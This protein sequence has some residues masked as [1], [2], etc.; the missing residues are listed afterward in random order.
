MKENEK[1]KK[2]NNTKVAELNDE[3]LDNVAGGARQ[4]EEVTIDGDRGGIGLYNG[5]YGSKGIADYTN[6]GF[7]GFDN[8]NKGFD[9]INKGVDSTDKKAL[10]LTDK[11]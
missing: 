3:E 4:V 9:N 2:V 10:N 5:G 1:T 8:I 7:K 11:K 6:K